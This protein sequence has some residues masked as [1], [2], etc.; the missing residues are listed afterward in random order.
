[1]GERFEPWQ[2]LDT[3]DGEFFIV[4]FEHRPAT[5]AVLEVERMGGGP[6]LRV[7]FDGAIAFR[8]HPHDILML[9]WWGSHS[10]YCVRESAWAGWL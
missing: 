7:W 4:W 6:V 9:T 1:M 2:P 3:A 8:N 10:F 5:G